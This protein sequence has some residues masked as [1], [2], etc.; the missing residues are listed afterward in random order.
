M[1]L[2][3][4]IGAYQRAATA[5][6]RGNPEPVKALWARED[7]V[8]LANPFGPAVRGWTAAAEALE[9]ASSRFR[10]GDAVVFERV[11]EYRCADLAVIHDVERWRAKV[12]A[13]SEAS[14]LILRVTSTF[15]RG[16]DGW[17]LVHR[18][19][20]TISAADPSGRLPGNESPSDRSRDHGG[21]QT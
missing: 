8:V 16:P 6:A 14:E 17:G 3:D 10:D 18:H 5:F 20:D 19:A 9:S 15:R 2:D 12:G 21:R 11:A 13:S 4:L 1:E 7:D